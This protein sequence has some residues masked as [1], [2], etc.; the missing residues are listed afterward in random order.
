MPISS[1]A[2]AFNP[3]TL[4]VLQSA[5]DQAWSTVLET[6]PNGLDE[7]SLRDLL[8]QRIVRAA[9]NGEHDPA[10][11]CRYALQGLSQQ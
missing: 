3:E 11:L 4:V 6:Q 9:E 1:R 8:A 7:H 5:F 2:S 10:E